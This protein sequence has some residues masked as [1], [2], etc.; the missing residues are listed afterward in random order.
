VRKAELPLGSK[1]GKAGGGREGESPG[2]GN[3][4]FQRV[5]VTT[6]RLQRLVRSIELGGVGGVTTTLSATE[7]AGL[8]SSS[9]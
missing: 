3:G 1:R 5:L 4:V 8:G 2:L 9:P 7:I 6:S